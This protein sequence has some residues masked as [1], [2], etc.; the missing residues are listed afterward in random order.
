MKNAIRVLLAILLVYLVMG[1]VELNLNV[2]EW[3]KEQR[4]TLLFLVFMVWVCSY[5][6]HSFDV[7]VEK[8]SEDI[9]QLRKDESKA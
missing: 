6:S 9:K 1:F 7:F 2:F 4:I 8:L 5:L 3:T